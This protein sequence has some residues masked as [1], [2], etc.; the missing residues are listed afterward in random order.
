M[1]E[2]VNIQNGCYLVSKDGTHLCIPRSM[3]IAFKRFMDGKLTGHVQVSFKNGGIA[4]V[5]DRTVYPQSQQ[6]T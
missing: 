3:L 4:A 6:G 2:S 1:S 5:E